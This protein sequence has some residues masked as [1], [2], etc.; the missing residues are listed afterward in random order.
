MKGTGMKVTKKG[1]AGA[2]TDWPKTDTAAQTSYIA[3]NIYRH[4]LHILKV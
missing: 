2:A 1:L 3:T 4:Q